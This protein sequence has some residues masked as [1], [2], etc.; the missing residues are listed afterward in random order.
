MGLDRKRVE[1]L[2]TP[3]VEA[4]GYRV[5]HIELVGSKQKPLLRIYVDVSKGDERR[6]VNL[7]DCGLISKQLNALLD[8]EDCIRGSYVLEVSS[9]GLDRVLSKL[10][11]FKEYVGSEVK[12]VL[13]EL[14]DGQSRFTGK[15]L[16]ASNETLKL[17][18]DKEI[19]NLDLSSIYKAK[20]RTCSSSR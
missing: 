4:M 6:G 18:V 8:V 2:V 1:E 19:I 17:E 9:P 11:H 13:K 20:L 12:I 15:I 7:D 3:I 5:W 16:D 10:E 14:L